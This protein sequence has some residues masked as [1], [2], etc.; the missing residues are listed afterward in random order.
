MPAFSRIS[1]RFLAA[2]PVVA[3]IVLS[4]SLVL[5]ESPIAGAH[6]LCG[7]TGSPNGPFNL[8]T[9]EHADYRNNYARTLELAGY[10]QLLPDRPGFSLPAMES[11]P[12]ASGSGQLGPGFIPPVLLKSI[13]HLESNWAQANYEVPYGQVGPVLS[14]HDCGYGITQVTSGMQNVSGV[15]NL[16]QA[17]IGGHYAFNIARGARILAEKWNSAP[18]FRPVVGHRTPQAIEDWYYA[19][20]GYNGFAFKNHPMNPDYAWP[21]S[22][23][24]CNSARSFPYQ[25]LVIGCVNN[26]PSR[27][28]VR[29]WNPQAATL[30]NLS[31][32]AIFDRMKLEHWG[33]CS[34][35]LSCAPMD[36]PTPDPWHTDPYGPPSPRE[37]VIG[38]P[39][40]ALSTGSISLVATPGGQSTTQAFALG[41]SSSGVLPW[42]LSTSAPW[43][44]VSRLQGV[45]LGGDLGYT[46]QVINVSA[47]V[48]SLLP[49]T[50]TGYITVES[51]YALGAGATIAVTVQTEDGAII[52]P[53][54]GRL[55]LLI[56]GVKRHIPDPATFE[57]QG[58]AGRRII[59]VPA[60][61]AS[62]IPTGLPVP[63]VL[64][65]GRLLRPHGG[66][67][68][69]FV[70]E[71]GA[72][73]H[74]TSP[75]IFSQCGFAWDAV[76]V[77]SPR[78][79]DSIP[80][81]AP[82]SS[83]P[84]PP[85]VSFP[86]LTLLEST[87]GKVWVTRGGIRNWVAG[88]GVLADCRYTWGN[89]TRL[90]NS[91]IAQLPEGRPLHSC[92]AEGSLLLA[93]GGRLQVILAGRSHHIPDPSTFE[94]YGFD[95]LRIAPVSGEFIP[96]GQPIMSV[97]TTGSLVRP[98]GDNVPVFVLDG[99][100]KRHVLTP[101]VLAACGYSWPAV[102]VLSPGSINSIANGPALNAVPCPRL[103]V[104]DGSVIYSPEGAV[105]VT[106]GGA[107][108][109]VTSSAA[110]S[111]CRYDLNGLVPVSQALLNQFGVRDPVSS[112][113]RDG[114]LLAKDGKIY[115]VRVGVK[116][117]IPNPLTFEGAQL[118]TGAITP[119][120]QDLLPT[121]RPFPDSG[122]TG[123]LIRP[124]GDQVPVYVMDGG[125]KRYLAGP[126]VL[127]SCGYGWTAI[128]VLSA[129]TV[130]NLPSGSP[131]SGPP[132]P[133]PSFPDG[134]LF[135]GSD[136]K[137]WVTHSGQRRWVYGPAVFAACGY[138]IA[139]VDPIADS[140]IN[141]QPLGPDLTGAPCPQ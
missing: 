95:G 110:V 124:A 109:W 37:H 35:N 41:N 93:P 31:D 125:Q 60:D 122:A 104:G 86:D 126:A 23:Y 13:A 59:P 39:T 62:G 84:C 106:I 130:N 123:R 89:V 105:F 80:S 21:R 16:E 30:P 102:A 98:A 29:L 52:N 131:L 58:Y 135:W 47:D 15:P 136:G 3:L 14:S 36:I 66:E 17:M 111:D 75:G 51:M 22:S 64:A 121:G 61:W 78:A 76:A 138:H 115:L 5:V 9:Y 42:R 100:K 133:Q 53:P 33:P 129:T 24:D 137:V 83:P 72:K 48:S 108:K 38:V 97:L 34:Q 113:T 117:H 92:T 85:R 96:G 45:S 28:G 1:G 99:G 19:L 69:I 128:S 114:S 46:H 25:E 6:H 63:S 26:P 56:G 74:I 118:S 87:D 2:L 43:V 134:T 12:R 68:P 54:D 119:L 107:R 81:G 71:N 91:V 101:D 132:C 55:Y 7:N 27:G 18:E 82:L 140:V 90:P 49:G 88:P 40:V 79:V 67:V 50:H 103:P 116:R 4:A 70:M 8:Q 65:N 94:A 20:W 73:R 77:V 32:P 11:G 127:D 57:A 141:A 112:C 44:R 10:N 120:Q 139:N